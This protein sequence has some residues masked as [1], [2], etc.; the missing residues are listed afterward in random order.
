[1]NKRKINKMSY[2]KKI[3]LVRD[4]DILIEMPLYVSTSDVEDSLKEKS[5]SERQLEAKKKLDFMRSQNYDV[6]FKVV[7]SNNPKVKVDDRVCLKG[8]SI[9]ILEREGQFYIPDGENMEYALIS[10]SSILWK[11][12]K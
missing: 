9:D 11:I 12:I 1:M 5:E 2:V 8:R 3:E 10:Q 6:G 4:E 7:Q